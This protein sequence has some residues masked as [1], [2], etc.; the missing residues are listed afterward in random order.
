MSQTSVRNKHLKE[1]IDFAKVYLDDDEDT[2]MELFFELMNELKVSNL[3][4]PLAED[5]DGVIFEN[6][7]F[8]EDNQTFIPLF[9]D[10][11]E[12]SAY[13]SEDSQFEPVV[14]DF[15]QYVDLVCENDLDGIII[16]IEGKY[17]PLERDFL[18]DMYFESET[19]EEDVEAYG[20][21]KLKEVLDS[22]DNTSLIELLTSGNEFTLDELFAQLSS[23]TLLNLVVSEESLD[24]YADD[25]IIN[26]S[27]VDGFNLCNV[28]HGDIVLGGIY[29]DIDSIREVIKNLDGNYYVQITRLTD[30]F[31]FIL[32]NDMDGVMINPNTLDCIIMRTDFLPQASGIE[33]IVENP[34]FRNCL[35]YAFKI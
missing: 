22:I 11:D 4:M 6:V 12:F 3:I 10:I 20:A 33:V 15:N 29:T 25:G 26:A 19:A 21:S 1:T 32:R 23:S 5:S 2:P 34:K 16:N 13:V 27:D 31:D 17:L 18:E 9:T 35:E 14:F 30:L 7:T 8:E 28:E 24:G